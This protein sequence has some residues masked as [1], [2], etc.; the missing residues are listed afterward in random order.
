MCASLGINNVFAQYSRSLSDTLQI[1]ERSRKMSG[2]L[3][4]FLDTLVSHVFIFSKIITLS[5][6]VCHEMRMVF[7]KI[8]ASMFFF[9][10]LLI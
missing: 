8:T 9:R 6:I 2:S 5:H 7:E 4:I 1:L 10:R 3:S